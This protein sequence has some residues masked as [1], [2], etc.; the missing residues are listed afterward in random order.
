MPTSSFT[1]GNAGSGTN[2]N[3]NNVIYVQDKGNKDITGYANIY[4]DVQV[5][6]QKKD[7]PLAYLYVKYDS[8]SFQDYEYI[9][10][11]RTNDGG[12][13]R[14]VIPLTLIGNT[15]ALFVGDPGIG[16]PNVSYSRYRSGL[17]LG[18]P[19]ANTTPP[20]CNASL[21]FDPLYTYYI[22][23][24]TA[25]DTLNLDFQ[26]YISASDSAEGFSY[27]NLLPNTNDEGND[28]TWKIVLDSS[29]WTRETLLAGTSISNKPDSETPSVVFSIDSSDGSTSMSG[30]VVVGGD[31]TINGTTTTVNTTNLSVEDTIIELN[32]NGTLSKDM[33]FLFSKSVDPKPVFY[34]NSL[35]NNR[36]DLALVT[37]ATATSTNLH[38]LSQTP[39]A[40]NMG[41]LTATTGSFSSTLGVT[42]VTTLGN[43]VQINWASGTT[44][45]FQI[46]QTGLAYPYFWVNNSGNVQIG[47][48]GATAQFLAKIDAN[49]VTSSLGTTNIS[50][51]LT[52]DTDQQIK[53]KKPSSASTP[54]ILFNSDS[55]VSANP[56]GIICLEVERGLL[57]NS[58][59]KWDE[60]LVRWLISNTLSTELLK[61][62]DL[63]AEIG[64][65][66]PSGGAENE[67]TVFF[68]KN[69]SLED[70]FTI[71][72]GGDVFANGRLSI[73]KTSDPDSI[74]SILINADCTTSDSESNAFALNVARGILAQAY[75]K[76]DESNVRW[77]ISHDLKVNNDLIVNNDLTFDKSIY[78][79]VQNFLTSPSTIGDY[80][81]VFVNNGATSNFVVNL[82]TYEHNRTLTVRVLGT[83][84]VNLTIT[85]Y[86]GSGGVDYWSD[87]HT[88]RLQKTSISGTPY[89][90][91]NG[92]GSIQL[93]SFNNT[94]YSVASSNVDNT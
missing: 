72:A 43:N 77:S 57:T 25:N 21:V 66:N 20:T 11:F 63:Q 6:N 7:A 71:T 49:T 41:G 45:T 38:S 30:D 88:I 40:L 26:A 31:L 35:Y 87:L 52:I 80:S 39:T 82:P 86:S 15:L 75:L 58:Y 23:I 76:W 19:Y 93:V 14:E 1:G 47:G 4:G 94:W 17:G 74:S 73:A 48:V 68:V 29:A 67:D 55:T 33:G 32:R 46:Q 90:R 51:H 59:I 22:C 62:G 89:I 91:I 10:I 12:L 24:F 34:W 13:T 64:T 36:F 9:Y 28:V 60:S 70:S 53:L 65:F 44:R 16:I 8:D 37:G 85:A 83:G 42:G 81:M 79:S 54:A 78:G 92:G 50:G 84:T 56:N 27:I 18:N 3:V 2:K 5:Y 61:S 69:N